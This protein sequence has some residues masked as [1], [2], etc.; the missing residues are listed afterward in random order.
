[1]IA[2][3]SSAVN[4]FFHLKY[5]KLRTI[6]AETGAKSVRYMK[7]LWIFGEIRNSVTF[8]S[9]W[10]RI[11]TTTPASDR[12]RNS[13]AAL[14]WNGR[15]QFWHFRIVPHDNTKTVPRKGGADIEVLCHSIF[16]L[17]QKYYGVLIG[18]TSMQWYNCYWR[19]SEFRSRLF[20]SS[21]L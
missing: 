4:S 12:A 11:I 14:I 1:M 6:G 21:S 8:L 13:R 2:H 20:L 5:V 17:R 16:N 18:R 19:K 9:H 10:P 7:I 3:L 15:C